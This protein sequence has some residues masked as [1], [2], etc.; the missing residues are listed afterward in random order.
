MPDF[1]N[2]TAATPE[3]RVRRQLPHGIGPHP[4]NGEAAMNSPARIGT[5]RE[6]L[7]QEAALKLQ[8]DEKRK[9]KVGKEFIFIDLEIN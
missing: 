5:L 9:T 2:L 3:P 4:L 1:Y 7:T 6:R 8:Q